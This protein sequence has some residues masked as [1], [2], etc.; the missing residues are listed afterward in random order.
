MCKCYDCFWDGAAAPEKKTLAWIGRF[1]AIEIAMVEPPLPLP[2]IGIVV[3]SSLIF[4]NPPLPT[5]KGKADPEM[6]WLKK[7]DS[8]LGVDGNTGLGNMHDARLH[9]YED[10]AQ[11]LRDL[12]ADDP[13]H[14]DLILGCMHR[15]EVITVGA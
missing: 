7:Y 5:G 11:K 3:F 12:N 2:S 9:N 8:R 13:G 1:T 4:T 10:V 15:R 14:G 6:G